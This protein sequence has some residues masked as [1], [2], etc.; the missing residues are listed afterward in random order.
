MVPVDSELEFRVDMLV[1]DCIVML[2][3][4]PK[5]GTRS[6]S[7]EVRTGNESLT[8]AG[9]STIDVH[10]DV[11]VSTEDASTN[12]EE[13]GSDC[14]GMEFSTVLEEVT[15]KNK[16]AATT[17]IM[18]PNIT[19]VDM[20]VAV[21]REIKHM[22]EDLIQDLNNMGEDSD[23]VKTTLYQVTLVIAEAPKSPTCT[24]MMPS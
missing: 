15:A 24:Q 23:T 11:G 8:P 22:V 1:W 14:R 20:L 6:A 16:V 13:L 4:L 12:S 21:R 2:E 3:K 9:K 10:E 7:C 19:T 5:R 17:R 18:T